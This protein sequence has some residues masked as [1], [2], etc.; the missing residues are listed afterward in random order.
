MTKDV[1][2]NRPD[3]APTRS[4]LKAIRRFC[5]DCVGS[6]KEVERCCDRGCATW[7]FRF[8]VSPAT[9]KKRGKQV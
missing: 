4:P 3:Y 5:L 9:A 8:G 1:C 7:P 6:S 2:Y